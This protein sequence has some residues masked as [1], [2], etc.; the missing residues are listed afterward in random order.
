MPQLVGLFHSVM[1]QSIFNTIT[2]S[3]LHSMSTNLIIQYRNQ[4]AKEKQIESKTETESCLSGSDNIC[5]DRH[6]VLR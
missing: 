4:L 3:K 2:G 1:L 5:F 6:G